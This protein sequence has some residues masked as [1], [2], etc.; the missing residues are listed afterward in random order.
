MINIFRRATGTVRIIN[1][2]Y[3]EPCMKMTP[4]I[5][6]SL[7]LLRFYL[8]FLVGIMVY[9]FIITLHK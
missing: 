4:A 5:R 2:K 1:Q 7:G 6:L 9:K 3:A 8:L